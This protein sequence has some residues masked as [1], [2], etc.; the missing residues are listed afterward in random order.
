MPFS[1]VVH[2][3]SVQK[4]E[5]WRRHET[6]DPPRYPEG[7]CFAL[8]SIWLACARAYHRKQPWSST[9]KLIRANKTQLAENLPEPAC[10][11]PFIVHRAGYPGRR[12]SPTAGCVADALQMPCR[13]GQTGKLAS[14]QITELTA[15]EVDELWVVDPG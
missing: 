15:E 11:S 2:G 9:R 5:R 10:T 1:F 4:D 6:G 3:A 12:P 8:R 14:W 13:L 7:L